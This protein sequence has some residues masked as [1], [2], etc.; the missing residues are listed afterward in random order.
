M[1]LVRCYERLAASL[2][3]R[4]PI[5]WFLVLFGSAILALAIALPG[6]V[7]GPSARLGLALLG[8]VIAYAGFYL[9]G[10]RAWFAGPVEERQSTA[11]R[12]GRLGLAA[13]AALWGAGVI[14]VLGVVALTFFP[15]H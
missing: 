14:A 8:A 3:G 10:I 11:R 9:L 12:L 4:A 1:P 7:V 15:R 6:A 2:E 13:F 5:L